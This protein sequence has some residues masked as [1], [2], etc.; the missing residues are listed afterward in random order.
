MAITLASVLKIEV[1]LSVMLASKAI[2]VEDILELAPGSVIQFE[3]NYEAPL[4]LLANGKVIGEGVAVKVNEK[5]GMQ[6]KQ[7]GTS[8]DTLNALKS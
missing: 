4:H 5:F 7:M 8:A 3:K 1:P 2:S 6:I